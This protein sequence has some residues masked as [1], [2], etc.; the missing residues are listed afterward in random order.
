MKKSC[1][2]HK[3][4]VV[5]NYGYYSNEL[6][7]QTVKSRNIYEML[8]RNTNDVSYFDTDSFKISKLNIFK[9]FKAVIF[10]KNI[11]II[12]AGNF[13]KNI[14]PFIFLISKMLRMNII[15]IP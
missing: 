8:H 4:L 7:G 12:P 9:L 10:S 13:L 5:G 1:N 14:F 2:T 3:V 11:V 6:D 15:C